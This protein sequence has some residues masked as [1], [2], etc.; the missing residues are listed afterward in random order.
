MA[1]IR[2]E[3]QIL[4]PRENE[5]GGK[6]CW[7]VLESRQREEG[8]ERNGR[9]EDSQ[10]RKEEWEQKDHQEIQREFKRPKEW[11]QGHDQDQIQAQEKEQNQ[12]QEKEPGQEH[13]SELSSGAKSQ[14][15]CEGRIEGEW[16]P[17]ATAVDVVGPF[18][19]CS[20]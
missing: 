10:G 19:R 11:E 1:A 8:D 4:E 20:E 13:L 9:E 2:R 5:D 17:S 18:E 12:E 3:N 6:G 16:W 14:G 15:D 7:S